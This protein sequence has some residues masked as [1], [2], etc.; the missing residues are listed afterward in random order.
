M[1]ANRLV[2]AGE[3]PIV[4]DV[5]DVSK[6]FVLRRDKS[7]KDRLLQSRRS[8]EHEEAFWALRDVGLRLHGGSTTGLIG[9]NG[10]GKSTL[11]KVIGGII[12][13][14]Q[15]SVATRGRI[16]ALLELG[17]GFHPDL[18]G[19][20]NVYLNAAILGM[21]KEETHAQFDAIVAFSGIGQFI[22]TQVKFYSSGM[23]VR[24]AF[25]VAVHSDPDILLVDEVLAVGDEEFQQ[26]CLDKIE[27]FQAEGRA[28][29]LVSHSMG[30]ITSLCDRAVVLQRGRL[31]FDGNPFEAVDVMRRGLPNEQ[32]GDIDVVEEETAR[33]HNVATIHSVTPVLPRAGNLHAGETLKVAVDFSVRERMEEWDLTLGLVNALGMTVLTTSAQATGLTGEPLEGRNVIEFELP[34]L[35]AGQG[36][37]S[38]TSAVFDS[39][40]RQVCRR[41][42]LGG[43][44]MAAGPESIGPVYSEV[45]GRLVST[46]GL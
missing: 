39:H 31:V 10:S 15:G 46:S 44:Q 20:D 24:L 42:G 4:V 30:Q 5:S 3:G 45:A 2:R 32:P 35:R 9:P 40:Q 8:K 29:V 6:K 17:A 26:K 43:F 11:L 36:G 18:S 37:Y 14:D 28:I 22:D 12:E 25:S 27:E 41:E 13:P 34:D 1:G 7:V 38:L 23:Y 19:R 21:S 16:A 33:S